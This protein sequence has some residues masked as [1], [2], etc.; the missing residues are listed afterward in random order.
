MLTTDT[1][2]PNMTNEERTN[3]ITALIHERRLYESAG[4]TDRVAEV[5]AELRKLGHEGATPQ[6]RSER[7]P[8]GRAKKSETR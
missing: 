1:E 6:K 8:A 4:R 7:R 2:K 3:Q 5:D